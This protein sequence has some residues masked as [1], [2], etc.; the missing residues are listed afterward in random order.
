V[1]RA[2]V[3]AYVGEAAPI[4]SATL[5]VLLPHK[6]SAASVRNT[7]AELTALNLLEQPH[8]SAGRVPTDRGL[9]VFVDRLLDPGRLGDWERRN[10]DYSVDGASGDAVVSIASQLL[11]ER[12][13]QLG[14]VLVPPVERLV[15]RHVSLVRL[16]R[17]RVLVVL[18][19]QTGAAHRRVIE[20][21]GALEQPE[22]ER[23]AAALNERVV[24]RTLREVRAVLARE[25]EA[26]RYR[27][28]RLLAL[29][30]EFGSRALASM[31]DDEAADLVIATRLALLDQPEFRD[32]ERLRD[33]FAA[34]ETKERLVDVLD[35]VVESGGMSV[36]FG[37]E[38]DDPG[39]HRCAVVATPYGGADA[40]LGA[41]GVIG[42]S[43]MD[44]ARIIPLVEYLSQ[45]ITGKLCA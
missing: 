36:V 35:R 22:L 31:P 45:V 30:V 27:A 38:V 34:I 39:L 29:A 37:D 6:L 43:R 17:E 13:R 12:T 14:F 9:R 41:L 7:L 15:L 28:D 8:P 21:D 23:I 40:P 1:L 18:V 24:G 11:S 26:L 16:S 42:P 33:L 25:A 19:S 4:G 20:E 2:I 3:T 44:Y 10:I 5:S 32:P